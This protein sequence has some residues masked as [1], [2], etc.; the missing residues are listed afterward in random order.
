MAAVL[1]LEDDASVPITSANFGA[2]NGGAYQ[3]LKFILKNVG[4][5]SATSVQLAIA[6]LAAND[7][8]D[9]AQIAEDI[10]G[11]PGAY[12]TVAINVGTLVALAT[13]VFWIRVTVPLGATPAGNPR[14]F[15]LISTY[16]GV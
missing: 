7:G 9:F 14:Y 5:Q 16:T 11:N 8:I 1:E 3:E 10:G 15:D 4:D 13:K 6:R 2:V 12:S